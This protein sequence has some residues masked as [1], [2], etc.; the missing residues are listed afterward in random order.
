MPNI[1]RNVLIVFGDKC[2]LSKLTSRWRRWFAKD[3]DNLN[4]EK[5]AD[6]Q[7]LITFDTFWVSGVST[8]ER[9]SA[10]FPELVFDL[11]YDAPEC[12]FYGQVLIK[13]G[14][15]IE[16]VHRVYGFDR[17]AAVPAPRKPTVH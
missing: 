10:A 14:C 7:V 3:C 15:R 8:V 6:D 9:I 12:R 5:R 1:C 17:S 13:S 11:S 2:E 4:F 16:W